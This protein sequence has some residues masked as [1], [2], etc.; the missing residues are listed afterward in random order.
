MG[1]KVLESIIP[2]RFLATVGF[3]IAA[4][5]VYYSKDDNIRASLPATY[6]SSEYDAKDSELSAAVTLSVV[7]TC[8][9]ILSMFSGYTL[10]MATLSSFHVLTSALG[11]ILTCWFILDSWQA[12]LYWYITGFLSLLPLMA[13]TVFIVNVF[14][15]DIQS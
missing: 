3:L 13:E 11:A 7:C 8:L 5:M 6:S 12:P 9:Q 4:I 2:A 15:C 1:S 10:F 14:C